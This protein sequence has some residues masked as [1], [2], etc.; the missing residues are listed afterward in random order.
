M[1]NEKKIFLFYP[2]VS[3][4]AVER[5]IESLR[6]RW[7]G[8]G[9]RMAEF[10]ERFKQAMGMPYAVAVNSVASA[11]RL[12]L[13]ISDVGPG[14]EV[15]TTPQ[16]CTLTNHPILEQFASPVFADIQYLTG[17]IEPK[18]LE[19]RITERT[20]A[21]ICVHWGGYPCDLDEI[22]EVA[23]RHNLVVIE[24][25]Q[26]AIG[27]I[28]KKKTIGTISAFTCFSFGAVQQVTT[29]EG[30]MLCMLDNEKY[31]DAK[32]RRWFGI[33]KVRRKANIIGY[34]DFDVSE[35]GYSYHMT[36]IAASLGLEHLNDL[37]KIIRKRKDISKRYRS[38]LSKASGVTL[39]EEKPDRESAHQL[40]TIHV[41]KREDFCKM[42]RSKGVEVSIVHARN[43]LYTVFGG[44]RQDLPT[45]DKFSETNISIPL[46]QMLTDEDIEYIIRCIKGG[47]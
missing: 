47:W 19:H 2:H 16:T 41:E 24:D 7:I 8:Q 21:I 35:T 13:A 39:F 18:D 45:L 27:A 32:R 31:E 38:E 10:E 26:D 6:S 3:E 46:Y 12:A 28:Y 5:V 15:I 29:G 1:K 40:F 25:A 30:G 44:L 23:I 17:N 20:K 43:D 33:D 34:Y 42:M 37:R 14:D 22:H 4:K 36:D 9:P 11:I